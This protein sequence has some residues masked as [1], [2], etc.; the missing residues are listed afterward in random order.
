MR[1][2]IASLLAVAAL[3]AFASAAPSD[4]PAHLKGKRSSYTENGVQRTVFEH[5]ATGAKIDFVTNSGIC[6]TTPGV[7]QYSG[8]LTV[9]K[10]ENMWFWFFEARN[11]ASS[12]PLATWFNGGPGCSSMIGLFQVFDFRL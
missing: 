8:Y 2:S 9:G 4:M 3:P 7:N 11:N 5:E 12:A 6:E 1:L 10:N